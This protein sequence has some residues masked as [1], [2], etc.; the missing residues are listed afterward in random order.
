MEAQYFVPPFLFRCYTNEVRGDN[1]YN[2]EYC[3]ALQD[4]IKSNDRAI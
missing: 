3:Y 4:V 1:F 2:K